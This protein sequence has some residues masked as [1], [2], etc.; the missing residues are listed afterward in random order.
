MASDKPGLQ[1]PEIDPRE[2]R[3]VMGQFASGVTVITTI[4]DGEVRGMTANAFMSGSLEPPLCVVSVAK[5]ARMHR[6]VQETGRFVVNVLAHHQSEV[7]IHF[8]GRPN[9]KAIIELGWIDGL[10]M[11]R[12]ALAHMAANI[13]AEHECGDHTLFVGHLFHIDAGKFGQ[14]LLYHQSRFAS[15]LHTKQDQVI[16][17]PEFW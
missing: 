10:P 13:V 2:F 7:A 12:D 17:V 9:P 3:R 14:P 1:P 6:L 4:H 8:S 5:R 15:L 16:T 11:L